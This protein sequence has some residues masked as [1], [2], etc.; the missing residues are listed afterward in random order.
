M[1]ESAVKAMFTV[2]TEGVKELFVDPSKWS[3]V[4][5]VTPLPST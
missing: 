5:K 2:G 4:F 3:D 1:M